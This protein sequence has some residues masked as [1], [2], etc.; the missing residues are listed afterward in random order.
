MDCGPA[1]LKCL[2]E[3]FGISISYPRL[4]EACQTDIDGTSI[5]V[6]EQIA[7]R[8]GLEAEQIMIPVD[9][10]LLPAARALPALL[11]T[12]QPNNMLHFSSCG[13]VTGRSSRSWIRRRDDAGSALRISIDE[14]FVHGQRFRR[15]RGAS[16]RHLPN[17]WTSLG[18]RLARL[19]F[20]HQ[21]RE[22]LAADAA[23]DPGWRGL[24]TLDAATRMVTAIVGSGGL[25]SGQD[26]GRVLRTLV[27]RARHSSLHIER[28]IPPSYW[29]VQLSL[30]RARSRGQ[31]H[32]NP[33]TARSAFAAPFSFAYGIAQSPPESGTNRW[34]SETLT[35]LPHDLVMA[36]KEPPFRPLREVTTRVRADGVLA[37]AVLVWATCSVPVPC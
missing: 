16:G 2:L 11:V 28:L 9:H 29:S 33:M 27:E 17:S 10:L 36:L 23:S 18:E 14:I 21:L 4:Q 3:G 12:R 7:V 8:L 5:N 32:R 19:G 37:P 20:R 15:V 22:R 26:A 13:G 24:A 31:I 34:W 30:S 6:I 1:S 25:R 35:G